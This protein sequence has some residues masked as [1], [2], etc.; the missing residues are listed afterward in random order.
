[1]LLRHAEKPAIRP[2][3]R[4]LNPE[5][6]DEL[7]PQDPRAVG[8]RK[9]LQRLNRIMGHVSILTDLWR[10]NQPDRWIQTIIELGAG[11]GTFLLEF[12][13]AIAPTSRPYNVVLVDRL[14]AI[15][16]ET[17]QAFRDL[18]W[19][20]EVVTEDVFD[21]LPRA[22]LDD[23]AIVANL[24]LHHFDEPRLTALLEAISEKASLFLALEPRRSF[25]ALTASRLVGLIG[26]NAVTRHDA[27]LSVQAGFKDKELLSMWPARGWYTQEIEVGRFTHCFSAQR[28]SA[29]PRKQP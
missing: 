12:A 7:A 14:N 9:D 17:L 2:A 11:D 1:M 10:R 23:A 26:C 3:M 29:A 22:R 5:W 4:R 6:L 13:R 18:G 24:F 8:S 20:P 21:W 28:F 19:K 25:G 16:P 27:V 15:R